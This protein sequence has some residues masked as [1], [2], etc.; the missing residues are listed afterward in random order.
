MDSLLAAVDS[1][2]TLLIAAI[3]VSLLLL[4]L[5]FGILKVSLKPLLT[6]LA[7]ALILQ[8]VFGISPSQLWYEIGQLPY[9]IMRMVNSFG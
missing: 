1:Q 9:E 8:Y 6:I 5:V 4:N 3:V 7:I 2:T